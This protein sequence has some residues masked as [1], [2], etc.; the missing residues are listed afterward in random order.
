MRRSGN[1]VEDWSEEMKK[2]VYISGKV[3]GTTD[4]KERF[5]AAAEL[6]SRQDGVEVINPVAF[7][8]NLPVGSPWL[9]YMKICLPL[10]LGG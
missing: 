10:Y 6:L 4:Y 7:S 2:R 9:D 1:G 3:T 8:E 5:N